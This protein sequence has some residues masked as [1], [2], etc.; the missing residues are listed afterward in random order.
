MFHRVQDEQAN[1]AER[2]S[3]ALEME[4][5]SRVR[6]DYDHSTAADRSCQTSP[7]LNTSQTDTG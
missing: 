5:L 4:R 6:T 2:R 1:M 7:R 3:E